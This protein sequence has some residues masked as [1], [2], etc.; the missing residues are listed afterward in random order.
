MKRQKS[1]IRRGVR[2]RAGFSLGFLLV[3]LGGCASMNRPKIPPTV[4]PAQSVGAYTVAQFK[5]DLDKYRSSIDAT[6][7]NLEAARRQRDLILNRIMV[8]IES[9]YK[10]YETNLFSNRAKIEVAGDILE[11]GI[12]AATTISN[13]AR[14]KTVLSAALTGVKG[15]R[16]SFDKNYFR[17]K[18]TEIIIS[19]MQGSRNEIRNRITDKMANLSV[20]K[21]PFEEGWVDLID[22]FYAGTLEG[23]LE[24][25]AAD[26]GSSVAKANAGAQE[27]VQ[28][29]IALKDFS[30]EQLN[31]L[32][33]VRR[34]FNELYNSHNVIAAK[35]ALQSLGVH[36]AENA[37]DEEVF[38]ALNAEIAKALQDPSIV[39]RLSVALKLK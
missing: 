12:S 22:F 23:G 26:A 17:E 29:R 33:L 30:P 15:S 1:D 13:P 11:L 7:P 32:T 16:L 24:A 3:L 18:T 28:N 35:D 9:D 6:P 25:L 36:I 21:Y 27:S 5:S 10:Q 31:G 2:E 38:K 37:S 34:K 19:R 8:D 4:N 20:D 39:Q 14:V